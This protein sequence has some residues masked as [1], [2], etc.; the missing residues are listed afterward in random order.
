VIYGLVLLRLILFFT[1]FVVENFAFIYDC[2]L[3]TSV[4][5][6]YVEA[7]CNTWFLL[8]KISIIY[9]KNL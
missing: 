1:S 7:E 2:N 8:N 3:W 5:L 6:N 4:Y 9:K